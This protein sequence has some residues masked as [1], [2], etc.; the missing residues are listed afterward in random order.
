MLRNTQPTSRAIQARLKKARVARLA[1]SDARQVHIVPVCFVYDGAVFYTALDRKPK[2]V[3]PEQL[4]RVRNIQANPRVALIIDEYREDWNRLWY[5]LVRGR[6][7]LIPKS[8]RAER[9]KAI[10]MLKAKYPQYAAGML[11]EDAPVIRI[12]TEQISPWGKF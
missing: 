7:K 9:L 12:T 6:A 8:A 11:A 5:I 2:R 10:R 3:A 1:T 4:A